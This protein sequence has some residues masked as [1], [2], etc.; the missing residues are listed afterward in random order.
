MAGGAAPFFFSRLTLP[1]FYYNINHVMTRKAEK[2]ERKESPRVGVIVL[3]WNGVNRLRRCLDSVGKIDYP[4]FVTIVVD[5]ASGDGSQDLVRKEYPQAILLE[6]DRNLGVAGGRNVGLRKAGELGCDYYLLLDNDTAVAPGL[7][8]ELVRAGEER[9]DVGILG[10]KIYFDSE[11]GKI[12]WAYGG[13]CNLYLCRMDAYGY[14][15]LDTGQFDAPYEPDYIPGCLQMIKREVIEE[16]GYLDEDFII[17]FAEDTDLCLRAKAA[18]Y[19]LLCVPD[20]ILWHSVSKTTP[21]A[22]YHFLKGRNV[23]L[24]MRKHAKLRHW[25][26]FI[27]YSGIGLLRATVRELFRGNVR[28]VLSM[29]KGGLE[30]LKLTA[31]P[32]DKNNK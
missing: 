20:A 7:L 6:N 5:N 29:I 3:N 31:K 9:P 15:K 28:N 18:G 19:R 22:N 4:A 30:N 2:K 32:P 8:S 25:L 1:N 24:F 26:V 17:Y 14:G 10:A 23:F 13:G 16:V 21:G 12:V 27:P 11:G